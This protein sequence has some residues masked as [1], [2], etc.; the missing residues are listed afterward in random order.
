MELRLSGD[1]VG[2]IGFVYEFAFPPSV[3]SNYYRVHMLC[4]STCLFWACD[5]G[6]DD[7]TK[8]YGNLHLHHLILDILLL[9]GPVTC[10]VSPSSFVSGLV[11]SDM[12]AIN[13]IP[14]C[15][16]RLR[17]SVEDQRDLLF[18]FRNFHSL[19]VEILLLSV[20]A[21]NAPILSDI[22]SLIATEL[23]KRI[24]EWKKTKLAESK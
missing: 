2:S 16:I 13:W 7:E 15:W 1:I 20:D 24:Q 4:C 3:V 9:E 5:D 11:S 21:A 12:G 18:L 10:H 6:D 19:Y 14:T 8:W 22:R 17:E 23:K